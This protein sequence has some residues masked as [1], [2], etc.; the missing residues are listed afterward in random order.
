MSLDNVQRKSV[1]QRSN[2]ENPWDFAIADATR[3]I[4]EKKSKIKALR[5][6]IKTFER[7]RDKGVAYPGNGGGVL[8][9]DSDL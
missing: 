8:G 6:S 7:L 3:L 2:S 1:R 4:A 5:R 9:Q